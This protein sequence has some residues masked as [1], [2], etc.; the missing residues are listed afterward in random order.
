MTRRLKPYTGRSE[1]APELRRACPP[2]RTLV[3]FRRI[4]V[5]FASAQ[6]VDPTLME[7]RELSLQHGQRSP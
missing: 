5:R 7:S 2:R 6:F 4:G 1:R 3:Q